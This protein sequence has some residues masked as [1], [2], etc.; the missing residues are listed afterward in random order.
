MTSPKR[1]ATL[2]YSVIVFVTAKLSV[3]PHLVDA[4][5]FFSP[6]SGGVRR[7]LLAKHEWLNQHSKLRHTL[8]V[9]GPHDRGSKGGIIEFGSPLL[10]AGYRCPV[11]LRALRRALTELRPGLLE[12][13]DPYLMGWQVAA[14]ARRLQVPCIAFCHSDIIGLADHR[15][16]QVGGT[17]AARYLR[18]LYGRFDL[19]LAPSALV[20]NRLSDAGI[21]D[22]AIQPLGVDPNIFSPLHRDPHLRT[23]LGLSPDT[24]L[25]VFAGRC[26]PEKN[27]NDLIVMTKL[28]G[29]GYHLLIIGSAP[30]PVA[31]PYVTRLGYLGSPAALAATLSACDALVHAGRQE[32]FGLVALE[33]MACGLPVIAY[34]AGAMPELIDST[35]GEL[36]PPTGPAALADAV[37]RAFDKDTV[38]SGRLARE[39]VLRHYTWDIALSKQLR[40]YARLLHQ[41]LTKTLLDLQPAT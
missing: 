25:L 29:K 39:R 11:R 22:V 34:A 2:R 14:V 16:G 10:R 37:R 41:P 19:V 35:V 32:T 9:P 26:A 38:H 23:R 1:H 27:V 7:Y 3:K 15:L 28:L 24:R 12:A 21:E 13:A 20:A 17:V 31:N 40:H 6:T 18:S 36:A 5:L 8:F 30:D 33:A 4:T